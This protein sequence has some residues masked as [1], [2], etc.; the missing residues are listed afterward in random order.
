MRATFSF[1]LP[2]EQQEF[3]IFRKASSYAAAIDALYRYLRGKRKYGE[4]SDA[5][6]LVYDQVWDQFH[7]ILSDHDLRDW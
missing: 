3:D 2:E 7:A 5:E 1:S 4:L 6:Q